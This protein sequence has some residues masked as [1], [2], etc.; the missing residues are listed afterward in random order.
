[1]DNRIERD[2]MGELAVPADRYYGAQTARSLINFPIGT[3]KMPIE[4]I[5]AFGVLKQAAA[6]TNA[7]LGILTQEQADLVASAAAEVADGKLDDHF[8]LVV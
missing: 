7:D 6:L 8:P 3:E 1:M 2:T 4:V 5:H